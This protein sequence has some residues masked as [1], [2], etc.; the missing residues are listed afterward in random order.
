[1]QKVPESGRVEGATVVGIGLVLMA[2]FLFTCLNGSVKWL[3]LSHDPL[4][5]AWARQLGALVFMLVAFMPKHGLRLLRPR[6]PS[7]QVA[8]GMYLLGSNVLYFFGLS[9]MD[10][11]SGAAI[12]LTGPLM[13]TALS[14][15][16]L[17][18]KVGW[19][20]WL[21]VTIGFIGA[22]I[23]IRPGVDMRWAALFFLASAFCST[24]YQITTRHLAGYDNAATAATIAAVVGAAALTPVVPFVWDAPED[25]LTIGLFLA[26]G[27]FAGL[28][29]FLFTSAYR[30]AGAS[31]LAPFSYAHLLGA[32]IVGFI[33]FGDF[34]DLWTWVGAAIIVGAGLY[35]AHR[36]RRAAA[37]ES[38]SPASGSQ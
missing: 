36:E 32:A 12:Q 22:L 23:I 9:Y 33:L 4:M 34:P 30:Y 13:V 17:G 10:M 38:I 35:V 26:L 8:R 37:R 24:F 14:A 21:A 11:A 18:E 25:W 31:T 1:M 16:L 19:R 5:V 15:P 7:A 6:M 20:R 28:G 29:H 3:T 2:I 27:V